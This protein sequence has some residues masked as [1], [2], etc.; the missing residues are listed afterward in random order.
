MYSNSLL[1]YRLEKKE[2][3]RVVG[4]HCDR[5]FRFSAVRTIVVKL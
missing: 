2:R 3:E 5:A 4:T 1:S